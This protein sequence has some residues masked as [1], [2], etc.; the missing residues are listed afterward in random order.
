[1]K[2]PELLAPAGSL[3][4]F[5]AAISNGADAVY[6]GALSFSARASAGFTEADLI[7]AIR[8]A[9]LYGRRV[10]IAVNT[11]IKE[12]ELSELYLTLTR[13]RELRADA[14]I[15]QDLGVV[16]FIKRELPDLMIHA[17][18]QMAIHNAQGAKLLLEQGID[19]VVLAR[20]CD[21]K[22]IKA[23]AQT[24]LEIEVFV[25]G[26]QCVSVSGQCIFSSQLGGRSGNRGRCAQP[27]RMDYQYSGK[28]GAWLSPRDLNLINKLPDLVQAGVSA[29]KIEGRLK[30]PEYVAV[31]TK[32]YRQALDAVC[33]QMESTPTPEI[34][35]A[36]LQI[37]N[38]GHFCQGHA[39]DVEDRGLLYPERASHEGVKIGRI[40]QCRMMKDFYLAMAELSED[41][42]NEDSLRI[43][44]ESEQEF[45][46]SG[47]PVSAE[48][49]ATLRL[50]V[51]AKAGEVLYRLADALQLEQARDSCQYPRLQAELKLDIDADYHTT[52]EAK[53]GQSRVC[54]S[55]TD[56]STAQSRPLSANEAFRSISKTADSPFE[57]K[58]FQFS[59]TFPAFIPVSQLNALRRETLD[60][61]KE[62]MIEDYLPPKPRRNLKSAPIKTAFPSSPRLLV[63]YHDISYREAF[64]D[65]GADC[66]IYE[67]DDWRSGKI[68]GIL[69]SL[70]EG[71]ILCLPRQ[72]N[73]RDYAAFSSFVQRSGRPY[74]LMAEN[75]SQLSLPNA[76]A[77]GEGIPCWNHEAQG[78]LRK[79]EVNSFV[80]SREM[81]LDEIKR[82]P[83]EGV[84][85]I[86]PVYGRAT[87]MLLNHCPERVICGLSSNRSQCAM[88]DKGKGVRGKALTDRY[89][90]AYPL[91]P[92]R[93]DGGCVIK[94][95]HHT[96]L[97]LLHLAD[98]A[99][100]WLID[101]S[102]ESPKEA[103]RIIAYYSALFKGGNA[104]DGHAKPYPGRLLQGVE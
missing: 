47:P 67:P 40:L 25:H 50:R 27:C 21:L 70:A 79:L 48:A 43:K 41:L 84:E 35:R 76:N 53:C 55:G 58:D 18:T 82:L 5:K 102:D 11:L 20:E 14:V 31:V 85:L 69:E 96:P 75:L 37:F 64:L 7:L 57:I 30:R 8:T 12:N 49:T 95:L 39:F 16:S 13:I 61:L 51:R 68:P 24:G 2:I 52:L 22:T 80:L 101:L 32:Q 56:A 26:A 60:L 23:A 29:F 72:M 34:N 94:L 74:S 104:D 15:V 59:S 6:L 28:S 33:N 42:H 83:S 81:K 10:Y 71:D 87:L 45:L 38:R 46:Y 78:F 19:R 66:F 86:L 1:M 62:R 93:Y 98:R 73:E 54:V 92:V 99:F 17:S 65:E 63:R 90:C 77:A 97:N 44:G 36:L 91:M 88:C 4:S 9:H 103:L 100:S 89:Q 3:E